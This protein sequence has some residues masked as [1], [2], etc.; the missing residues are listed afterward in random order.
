[1]IVVRQVELCRQELRNEKKSVPGDV[2]RLP[3]KRG[4]PF[5]E[6]YLL[7]LNNLLEGATTKRESCGSSA[8]AFPCN[9]LRCSLGK[10]IEVFL[11]L[12]WKRTPETC[13]RDLAELR[14]LVDLRLDWP[15]TRSLRP[16]PTSVGRQVILCVRHQRTV[17]QATAAC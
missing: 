17:T 2:Q 9:W 15:I 5:E 6:R 12:P 3:L 16:C 7:P 11:E 4:F 1:M 14:F 8:T 10:E 13:D